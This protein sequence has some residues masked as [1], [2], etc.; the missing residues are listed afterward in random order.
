MLGYQVAVVT[1]K[2]S[3]NKEYKD[4]GLLLSTIK[5]LGKENNELGVIHFQPKVQ[6]KN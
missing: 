5:K 4:C 2:F 1:E 3:G 6:A